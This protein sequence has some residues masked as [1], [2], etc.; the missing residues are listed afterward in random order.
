MQVPEGAARV[1][2]ATKRRDAHR[3]RGTET[4]MPHSSR[5]IVFLS[6]FL[7]LLSAARARQATDATDRDEPSLPTAERGR[8][9]DSAPRPLGPGR[10][11]D[12]PVFTIRADSR[13]T[14]RS[15]IRGTD[16]D[17]LVSHSGVGFDVDGPLGDKFRFGASIRGEIG[18][19][20]F[21]NPRSFMPAGEDGFEDLYTLGGTLRGTYFIDDNWNLTGIGFVRAAGESDADIGES[22]TGGGFFVVGYA[23]SKDLRVGFGVGGTSRLED[24]ALVIPY[25][26]LLWNIN[27]RVRLSTEG[28]GVLLSAD[29]DEAK[30][31][32]FGIRGGFE[33]RD[34]RLD[35]SRPGF[36]DGVVA[37]TRV[38]VGLELV[39]KPVDGLRLTLEGGAV[40][41]QR[42]KFVED[43]G[44]ELDDF[45]TDPAPF[46]GLRAEYRF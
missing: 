24:D 39:W 29:L 4:F 17:V 27:D 15:D 23:F 31:W 25:I 1:G 35:D 16:T 8:D 28:L 14:F 6:T 36:R 11:D 7:L 33:L 30:N 2:Y 46:I 37:D 22:I 45:E 18:Y 19:Y 5:A 12:A 26:S 3:R 9:V 32:E 38:P 41:Y 21:N 10:P 40:V 34:Y 43:G 42:F 44:D 13:L 20:D